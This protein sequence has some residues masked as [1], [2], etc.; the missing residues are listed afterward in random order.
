VDTADADPRALV[1]EV[2]STLR[3]HRLPDYAPHR[4]V[5]VLDSANQVEAIATAAAEVMELPGALDDGA[6]ADVLRPLVILVREARMAAAAAII[7]A[8]R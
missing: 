1:E 4:A 2:L 8:A 5:R 3:G 6:V 7:D